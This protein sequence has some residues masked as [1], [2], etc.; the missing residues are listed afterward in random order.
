MGWEEKM[1]PSIYLD[2][3]ATTPVDKRVWEAMAPFSMEEYGNPSSFHRQGQRAEGALVEAHLRIAT[4]IDAGEN[5]IVFTSGTSE[6]N[7]LALQ[8][9]ALAR[10][11]LYGA[12]RL[13]VSA[14][15]HPSVRRAAEHLANHFGFCL[16]II[17]LDRY[18]RV[19][20]EEVRRRLGRDVALVSVIYASNEVGTINPVREIAAIC[21]TAGVPFHSDA[22][23]AMAHLGI[24]V[25][26]EGV[27]LLS[28]GAHKFYGPKGIGALYVRKGTPLLPLVLGGEQEGGRRAGTESVPLAMGMARALELVRADLDEESERLARLRDRLI[29]GVLRDVPG[30]VL[31]GDPQKR[32]P[33]HASFVFLGVDSNL[34]LMLLDNEGFACSSSSACKVGNVEPSEVLLAMGI[35]PSLAKGALRV[36]LG[37]GSDVLSIDALLGKLPAII[38]QARALSL[39]ENY[40]A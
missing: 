34:L 17:P 23:Q 2:Y 4:A 19:E 9:V 6:A 13:L 40:V 10:K 26:Q 15:E 29:T 14:A 36:T 3:A 25:R 8:G 18:G 35:E 5:E 22:A 32:L 21:R 39:A 27:D 33:N 24:S 38:E 31:T 1:K 28:F 30:A 16:E 7:N 37:R 20:P 11:E 12:D